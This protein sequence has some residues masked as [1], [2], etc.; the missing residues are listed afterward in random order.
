M[1]FRFIDYKMA[2]VEE[3]DIESKLVGSRLICLF[4]FFNSFAIIS[5]CGYDEMFTF[6]MFTI[7]VFP[8]RLLKNASLL[9]LYADFHLKKEFHEYLS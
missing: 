2:N 9:C 4:H 8:F 5:H 3:I 7:F 1:I 6:R